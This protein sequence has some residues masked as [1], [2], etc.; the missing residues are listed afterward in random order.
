[1]RSRWLGVIGFL[2]ALTSSCGNYAPSER[3]PASAH[4]TGGSHGTVQED[5]GSG[6]TGGDSR[7]GSGPSCTELGYECDRD[8]RTGEDCGT[9]PPGRTCGAS[10][11]PGV[12]S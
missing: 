9:C 10:G 3:R 12:C 6:G 11:T 2:G 8:P 4:A 7:E 5:G 1:M